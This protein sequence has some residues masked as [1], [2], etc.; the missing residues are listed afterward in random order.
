MEFSNLFLDGK[1]EG[2]PQTQQK[3]E[4]SQHPKGVGGG[5]SEKF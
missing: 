3:D 1:F 2:R 5:R 4:R